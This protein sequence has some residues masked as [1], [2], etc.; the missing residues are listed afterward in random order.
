MKVVVS[1][2][3]RVVLPA[4]IRRRDDIRA[5]RQFEI[6]RVRRGEYR[7]RRQGREPNEGLMEWLLSGREK[8]FF[9]PIESGFTATR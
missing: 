9:L 1:S 7:L 5:G 2:K 6:R 4:E 8:D 3:G